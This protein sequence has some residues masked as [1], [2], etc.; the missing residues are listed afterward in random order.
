[1]LPYLFLD[2][3]K[4]I[5]HSGMERNKSGGRMEFTARTRRNSRSQREY[6]GCESRRV[7]RM[8]INCIDFPYSRLEFLHPVCPLSVGE[9]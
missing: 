4:L 6:C 3:F 7:T 5:S 2:T 8:R 9:Q 1:M